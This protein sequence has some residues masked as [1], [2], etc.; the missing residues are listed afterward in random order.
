MKHVTGNEVL[1]LRALM[2]SDRW[3]EGTRR[4]LSPC[5]KPVKAIGYWEAKAA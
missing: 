5:R 3:E 2:L 1:Q 4:A